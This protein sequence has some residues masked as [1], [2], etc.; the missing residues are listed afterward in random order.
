MTQAAPPGRV[1]SFPPRDDRGRIAKLPE[2][3]GGAIFG[4]VLSMIVLVVIDGLFA[5]LGVGKF[6]SIS[7]WLA[8][9][10]T[11]WMF[12]EEFR[13]WKG[14]PG[15][16]A[17]ALLGVIVGLGLGVLISSRLEALPA[18]FNGAI[19][20]TFAV[21]IYAVLWFFGIRYLAD[22]FGEG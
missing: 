20:V 15:R 19:S 11:V 14:V 21:V 6:G 5:L 9:I 18:V 22:R 3:L 12:I 1:A 16:A 17:V 4:V 8:G 2:I 13:A 10:I 7:G